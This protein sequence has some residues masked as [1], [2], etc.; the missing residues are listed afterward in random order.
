MTIIHAYRR[1]KKHTVDIGGKKIEFKPNEEGHFIAEVPA[2][3][4]QDRLLEITEGYRAYVVKADDDDSDPTVSEFV[5]T[6]EGENGTEKT[7]DLRELNKTQLQEFCKENEI[8]FHHAAGESKLREAI[9]TF[10][11]G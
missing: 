4:A 7:I 3:A 8:S 5:L 9:V 10:M 11:K 2:G 6:I 1:S